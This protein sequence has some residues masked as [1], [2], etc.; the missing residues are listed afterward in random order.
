M[1]IA[2][3]DSNLDPEFDP[4]DSPDTPEDDEPD[5]VSTPEGDGEGDPDAPLTGTPGGL[6]RPRS[7]D[8]NKI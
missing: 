1:T 7:I 6:Q 3:L 5:T 8:T 4:F 2:K